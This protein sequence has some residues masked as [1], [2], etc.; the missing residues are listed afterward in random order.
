M[1]DF[2]LFIFVFFIGISVFSQTGEDYKN[3]FELIKKGFN[4]NSTSLIFD[5]FDPSLKQNT[6]KS[7]F[8]K[9][10]DSLR[11]EKGK[12]ESYNFLMEDNQEKS[13]LME[14]ENASMLIVLSLNTAGNISVFEI[15]DY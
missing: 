1:K 13:Y 2:N 7:G 5:K 15:K 14:F 9:L 12:V 8:E 4:D 6:D 11:K 10:I 3:T